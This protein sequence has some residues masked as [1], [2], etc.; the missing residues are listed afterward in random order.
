MK[1]A[2][3]SG[4]DVYDSLFKCIEDNGGVFSDWYCGITNN[5]HRRVAVEHKVKIFEGELVCWC[6]CMNK[7]DAEAVETA[8]IE[9]DNCAG[10]QGG[11]NDESVYVYVYKMTPDSVDE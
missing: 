2:G 3:K 6:E 5:V 10:G 7:H 8:L 1:M 11:G 9:S 4:Q